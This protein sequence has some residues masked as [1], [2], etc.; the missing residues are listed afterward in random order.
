MH[1][2]AL[3]GS[4]IFKEDVEAVG[5]D[6]IVYLAIG[7]AQLRRLDHP[8]A[9][10]PVKPARKAGSSIRAVFRAT[11][12]SY[13]FRPFAYILPGICSPIPSV[14]RSDAVCVTAWAIVCVSA[15]STIVPVSIS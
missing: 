5:R 2:I 4:K 11:I 12:V 8:K 13:G 14:V 9:G 10:S 15:R 3:G 7:I 6:R 1:R